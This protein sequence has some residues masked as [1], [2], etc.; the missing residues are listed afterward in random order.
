MLYQNSCIFILDSGI[1]VNENIMAKVMIY[2][3]NTQKTIV[4]RNFNDGRK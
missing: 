3:N 1:S 4:N 2:N